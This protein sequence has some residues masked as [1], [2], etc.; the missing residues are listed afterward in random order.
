M[1][2]RIN[3]LLTIMGDVGA[4]KNPYPHI[5]EVFTQNFGEDNVEFSQ[6]EEYFTKW[7]NSIIPE[8]IKYY[9][10]FLEMFNELEHPLYLLCNLEKFKEYVN[11][12]KILYYKNQQD[13]LNFFAAYENIINCNRFDNDLVTIW[14]RIIKSII[15]GFLGKSNFLDKFSIKDDYYVP[16]DDDYTTLTSEYRIKLL[17][18][19]NPKS[20]PVKYLKDVLFDYNLVYRSFSYDLIKRCMKTVLDDILNVL[21][22][23]MDPSDGCLA[24]VTYF[25]KKTISNEN[26]LSMELTDIYVKTKFRLSGKFNSMFLCR[27]TLTENEFL[28]NY[29]HSHCNSH[30]FEYGTLCLGAGPLSFTTSKLK[31]INVTDENLYKVFLNLYCFELDKYLEVESITG[32]P[33]HYISDVLNY[34]NEFVADNGIDELSEIKYIYSRN[35]INESLL[36]EF[37]SNYSE[38]LVE[39]LLNMVVVF[40]NNYITIKNSIIDFISIVDNCIGEFTVPD[41]IGGHRTLL[42]HRNRIYYNIHESKLKMIKRA[43]DFKEISVLTFKGE[44]KLAKLIKNENSNKMI[45]KN[46]LPL[47]WYYLIYKYLIKALNTTNKEF[48]R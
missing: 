6:T 14:N 21:E 5:K 26:D 16:T 27:T 18:D 25:P 43:E 42:N 46:K 28:S 24:V 10:K 4:I 7:F 45:L 13:E 41:R 47:E 31:T 37:F 39:N 3:E 11:L 20:R 23:E 34:G 44:D 40:N 19:K 30:N 36:K 29:Q 9:N 15:D 17:E 8:K 33:Y 35:V 48:V 1:K 32:G 12:N 22:K 2:K 38:V